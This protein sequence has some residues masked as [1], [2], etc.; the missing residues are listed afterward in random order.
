MKK[1]FLIINEKKELA[2]SYAKAIVRVEKVGAVA[3]LASEAPCTRSVV[4]RLRR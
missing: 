2:N 3:A 1:R 4:K